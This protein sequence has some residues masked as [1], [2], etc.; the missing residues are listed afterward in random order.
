MK[1]MAKKEHHGSDIT[2]IIEL[3][4]HSQTD[5]QT[6]PNKEI[7]PGLCGVHVNK[8]SSHKLSSHQVKRKKRDTF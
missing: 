2:A 8:G 7:K 5:R 4:T 6:E 1:S 3:K